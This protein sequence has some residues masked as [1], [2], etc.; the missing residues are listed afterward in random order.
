MFIPS[1][2]EKAAEASEDSYFGEVYLVFFG[3]AS[4]KEN[5]RIKSE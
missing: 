2:G 4:D 1:A 3:S 5:V